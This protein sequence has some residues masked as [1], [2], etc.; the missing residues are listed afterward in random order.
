MSASDPVNI[1]KT[2]PVAAA[3]LAN[4]TVAGDTTCTFEVT[5]SDV[6]AVVAGAFVNS[7]SLSGPSFTTFPTVLRVTPPMNAASVVVTYQFAPPGGSWDAGDDGA[8]SIAVLTNAVADVA[9][10]KIKP[11]VFATL[12]VAID[13]PTPAPDLQAISDTGQSP[14]DNIT[15]LN[16]VSR[17][18]ILSFTVNQTIPGATVRILADG[19]A[20]G[21]AVASGATT[22][23]AT[24]GSAA[25]IDGVHTIVARQFFAGLTFPPSPGLDITIDTVAPAT[26][27]PPAL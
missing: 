21:S 3:S 6:S 5:F 18:S 26:P 25:L 14:S 27:P 17:T 8:Y 15:K 1:D 20:I 16:N 23:V 22:T 7:L 9:G 19:V 4:I 13:R 10:N 24:N 2:P 11:A 12:N